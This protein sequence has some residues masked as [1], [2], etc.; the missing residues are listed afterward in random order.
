MGR[1]ITNIETGVNKVFK[2]L[3]GLGNFQTGT[4]K[5]MEYNCCQSCSWGN[6]KEED[7]ENV[8]FYHIQDL[9][10]LRENR[11]ENN[12]KKKWGK[13]EELYPESLMIAW[14]VKP[15]LM[16]TVIKTF[17][18]HRIDVRYD[19]TSGTRLEVEMAP[20]DCESGELT[21]YERRK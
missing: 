2:E 6:F 8:L 10:Y 21:I 9:E 11:R 17:L 19:G 18:K 5:T 16:D 14:S 15:E 20:L 12:W 1:P 3:V 7:G 4:P 13:T